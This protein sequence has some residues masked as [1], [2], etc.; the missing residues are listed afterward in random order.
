VNASPRIVILAGEASGDAHAARVLRALKERYPGVS[1]EG[2]GGPELEKEGMVCHEN[3]RDLS[4]M[5]IWEVMKRYG[6]FRRIFHETLNRLKADPPDLLLLVDY[7]GFNLRLAKALKG[8]GIPIVQ[9][10]CPQVWAW[11]A[12]RIPAM[13]ETLD[14]VLCIFPFEPQVFES[15][16]L[17]VRYCGHPMVDDTRDVQPDPGWTTGQKIA[18]VPGSRLQEIDRLFLPM[19]QAAAQFPEA[20]IRVPVANPECGV[21]MEELLAAHPGLPRPELVEGGMRPVVKGADA[22]LVTSG[23]A[24]LETALLGTPMLI[25]YKTSPLTYA[26]GKRLIRVPHIGMVNLVAEREVCPEFIQAETDPAKVA[27]ALR[28]LLEDTPERTQ[29]LQGLREVREK[30]VSDDQGR[31]VVQQLQDFLDR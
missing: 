17:D 30:L 7:P 22:A 2:F 31:N 5:G 3:I 18:L 23:T 13:A 25:L 1:A 14:R 24:T 6:M 8:S 11:K 19:L 9:Y 27:E 4:V 20:R 21:R 15:V 29:M 10:I 28:P 12:S 26:I 16:D